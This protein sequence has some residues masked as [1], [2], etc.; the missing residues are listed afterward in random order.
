MLDAQG[1]SPFD[2]AKE[3]QMKC[4]MISLALNGANQPEAEGLCERYIESL[5]GKA[6]AK[7][8]AEGYK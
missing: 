4:T 7:V 8:L 5:S 3:G 1:K 2:Y 6:K